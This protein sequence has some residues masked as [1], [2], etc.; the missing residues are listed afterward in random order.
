MKKL[1]IILAIVIT[2]LSVNKQD[3]VIIPKNSIRFRVIANSNEGKDQEIK[4][5]I[6][7]NLFPILLKTNNI[8]KLEDAR[9]FLKQE[10]PIFETII[11]K[12]LKENNINEQFQIN[13]GKN[14][15]PEKKYK[16]IVYKE[17]NY[18][19][20]VVTIGN[21]RGKNFWCVLFPP[22]CLVDEEKETTEYK[23]IIKE[24]LDKHF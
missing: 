4:K 3:K 11:D 19:S 22:L 1:I 21:G 23:S 9:N 15:F 7:N 18:E 17:G 5:L 16:D 13:Y 6:V 24:I 14:Y 2:I 8:Q 20:L 12:T 10:I